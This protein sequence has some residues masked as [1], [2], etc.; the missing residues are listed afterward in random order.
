MEQLLHNPRAAFPIHGQGTSVVEPLKPRGGAKAG[1]SLLFRII[2]QLGR[3]LCD[4][5]HAGTAMIFRAS[6]EECG[7]DRRDTATVL[8]RPAFRPGNN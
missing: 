5:G 7:N 2:K 8:N 3:V 4:A 6:V 1:P